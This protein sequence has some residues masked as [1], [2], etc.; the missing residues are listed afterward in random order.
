M[1]RFWWRQISADVQKFCRE[2][3]VCNRAEPDRR[4]PARP[5]DVLP[6]PQFPW[7]IVGVDFICHKS[8]QMRERWTQL[9]HDCVLSSDQ[10]GPFYPLQSCTDKITAEESADLFLQHV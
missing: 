1:A 6:L 4:G 2:C 8:T 10:D 9:C 7:E 3:V 5:L